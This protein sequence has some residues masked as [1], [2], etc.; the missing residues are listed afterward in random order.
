MV[1]SITP[2][3]SEIAG[4]LAGRFSQHRRILRLITR[5]GAQ[6]LLAESLRGEEEVDKGFRLQLTALSLDDAISLR[7][8]LGQPVLL[9]LMTTGLMD[10]PRSFHGH[11]TAAELLGANGGFARYHLVIEPWT[12][13]LGVGR[14]SRVFQDKTV[15]DILETVFRSYGGKGRLVPAW[16]FDMRA[17]L[18]AR[19]SAA[20]PWYSTSK[21]EGNDLKAQQLLL[22]IDAI[23]KK[24]ANNPCISTDITQQT[25]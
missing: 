24:S 7:S 2:I 15:F 1:G 17:G 6:E 5:T 20:T 23:V 8:L 9:E 13:L 4:E 11:V 3:A 25:M 10:A 21:R 16:R 14:D 22:D 12:A 19:T 18:I